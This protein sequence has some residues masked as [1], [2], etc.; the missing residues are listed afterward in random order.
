M[1]RVL[2]SSNNTSNL[3]KPAASEMAAHDEQQSSSPGPIQHGLSNFLMVLSTLSNRPLS[4]QSASSSPAGFVNNGIAAIQE[5]FSQVG[6]SIQNGFNSVFGS[7]QTNE[8]LSPAIWNPIRPITSAPISSS[9]P[10][11]CPANCSMV[12]GL[13]QQTASL[14][15][16]GGADVTPYNKYPWIAL[17]QYYGQNVGTGTLINDRVVITSGTIIANMIIFNQIKVLFG[18]LDPT[19]TVKHPPSKIFSVIR[20]KLHPQYSAGDQFNYNIGLLQLA[21]PVQITDNFMPICMPTTVST[22]SDTDAILAGWGARELGGESW[23]SLQSV[24]FPLYSF[25]ECNLAYP[26]STENNICGG[27]FGPASKEQHKT[28]CE[29]AEATTES[30]ELTDARVTSLASGDHSFVRSSNSSDMNLVQI[31]NTLRDQNTTNFPSDS[32]WP[33]PQNAIEFGLYLSQATN[34]ITKPIGSAFASRPP[35]YDPQV[36]NAPFAYKPDRPNVIQH[37][38]SSLQGNNSA[39]T[40]FNIPS[41]TTTEATKEEQS[42]VMNDPLPNPVPGLISTSQSIVNNAN[43]TIQGITNILSTNVQNGFFGSANTESNRPSNDQAPSE[44][45]NSNPIQG[46]IDG[47]QAALNNGAGVAQN[48]TAQFGTN[49]QNGLSNIFGNNLN[50]PIKDESVTQTT[51]DSSTTETATASSVSNRCI[52]RS[53]QEQRIVGGI[54]VE[55]RD[56]YPWIAFLTYLDSPAGQGS[57]INDRAIVTTATIIEG[58]PVIMHIRA[59]LG[60]YNRS[61]PNEN[62][63]SNEISTTYIHPGFENTNPFADNIG[64]LI[65]KTALTNFRSIC[66]PVPAT[67]SPEV[68]KATVIG[69]G[70]DY[71]GGPLANVLQQVELQMH[72]QLVC[73]MTAS[74]TTSNNLCGSTVPHATSSNAGA[75]C[76]GDGGDPL[77]KKNGTFWELIGVALDIPGHECGKTG[78]PVIFTNI[79]PYL[80]WIATYGVGC[81]C[82]VE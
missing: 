69:W 27:I 21:N 45:P 76:T 68:S 48:I 35:A 58:M 8:V 52:N 72:V 74:Q 65:L 22:F 28:S 30:K 62:V 17:L 29:D 2:Y 13:P 75:T 55:S 32:K 20:T 37:L 60:V 53:L 14:R 77:V 31:A 24:A 59:L 46:V 4:D 7:N 82:Y 43:N 64:L 57:L 42:T 9:Q 51:D 71:A 11:F 81:E 3:Y 47:S 18:V 54:D 39:I 73:N 41:S 63:S 5:S 36:L 1:Q 61:D 33:V 66:L 70:A 80:D 40:F 67:D 6:S 12:C 56:K 10:A 78:T 34:N 38:L 25:E 44:S 49:I 50:R 79:V 26:N 19:T 15:I 23:R 16:V